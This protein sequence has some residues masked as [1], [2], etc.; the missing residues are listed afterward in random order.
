[1]I[2]LSQTRDPVPACL[3]AVI[4]T[5][6]SRDA[7]ALVIASL[8]QLA[9]RTQRRQVHVGPQAGSPARTAPF[10]P[11][12]RK[13]WWRAERVRVTSPARGQPAQSGLPTSRKGLLLPAALPH[14]GLCVDSDASRWQHAV[15]PLVVGR[16]P[17]SW[18]REVKGHPRAARLACTQGS[19]P[20]PRACP[21]AGQETGSGGQSLHQ[22]GH[23]SL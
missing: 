17:G 3:S 16:R 22:N 7:G 8:F 21:P 1:M 14:L 23:V 19:A 15:S 6:P 20:R 9:G 5:W 4:A 11:R 2:I 12:P 13:A 10:P 18:S